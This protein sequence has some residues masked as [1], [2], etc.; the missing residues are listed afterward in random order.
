MTDTS[1]NGWWWEWIAL[2]VLFLTWFF[3]FIAVFPPSP[4]LGR[5]WFLMF[6][7]SIIATIFTGGIIAA[8]IDF[9][10]PIQDRPKATFTSGNQS[11][12]T[13]K[14]GDLEIKKSIDIVKEIFND[15]VTLKPVSIADLFKVIISFI[16]C[17][18]GSMMLLYQSLSYGEG[19]VLLIL[20]PFI[21]FLNLL[22]NHPVDL[23]IMVGFIAFCIGYMLL[24]VE[25]VRDGYEL[26]EESSKYFFLDLDL[27]SKILIVVGPIC[28]LLWYILCGFGYW[29]LKID[30]SLKRD[31]DNRKKAL[32]HLQS[33]YIGY[34]NNLRT[35]RH[36][37]EYNVV[38][39]EIEKLKKISTAGKNKDEDKG[40]FIQEGVGPH[41]EVGYAVIRGYG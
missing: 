27:G 40:L 17:T 13:F 30:E 9:I 15:D 7:V 25:G 35:A 24:G 19:F 20:F 3:F 37:S 14:I 26:R 11:K 34:F 32:K 8:I 29:L 4:H 41:E 31:L 1:N 16:L 10:K 22:F 23:F 18:T 12:T 6:V 21:G 36:I 2:A 38:E 33:K 5:P 39:K 28:P